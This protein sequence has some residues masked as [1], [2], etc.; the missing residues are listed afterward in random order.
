MPH[1]SHSLV[2]F[3]IEHIPHYTRNIYKFGSGCY[4]TPCCH[5]LPDLFPERPL[6]G[7]MVDEATTD[8]SLLPSK[9]AQLVT[10]R[11]ACGS[12][13][14]RISARTPTMLTGFRG[15]PQSLKNIADMVPLSRPRRSSTSFPIRNLL[16]ILTFDSTHPELL[17]ASLDHPLTQININ[18]Y[19]DM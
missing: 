7:F 13:S 14:V 4:T 12:C 6:V 2:T 15:I 19:C 5:I 8:V 9:L 18:K 10:F 17:R 16:T 11:L 3:G 1:A